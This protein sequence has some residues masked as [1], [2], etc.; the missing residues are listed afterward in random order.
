MFSLLAGPVQRA[1]SQSEEEGPVE[2]KLF[3]CWS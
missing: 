2:G 1:K 3:P